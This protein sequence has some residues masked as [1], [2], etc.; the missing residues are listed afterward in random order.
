MTNRIES[1]AAEEWGEEVEKGEG[2]E[3]DTIRNDGTT[4]FSSNEDTT[5]LKLESTVQNASIG[6]FTRNNDDST[7]NYQEAVIE[8]S[9]QKLK[10]NDIKMSITHFDGE[11]YS[12]EEAE[13]GQTD[14][15]SFEN[16]SGYDYNE[17]NQYQFAA[18]DYIETNKEP[19][20]SKKKKTA[21]LIT[22][23]KRQAGKPNVISFQTRRTIF[24]LRLYDSDFNPSVETE[25]G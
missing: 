6:M 3:D 1:T 16:G 14:T 21:N 8:V 25:D 24:G 13:G 12:F 20:K 4:N 19:K 22:R 23:V 5:E 15:T 11:E 9:T 7:S 18:G 17:E 10:D 2:Y